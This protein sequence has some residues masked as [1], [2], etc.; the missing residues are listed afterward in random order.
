MNLSD[1]RF[2]QLKKDIDMNSALS[3]AGAGRNPGD[4]T[5]AVEGYTGA[6]VDGSSLGVTKSG[7][8][9][10][11]SFYGKKD[12][13][14]NA[15]EAA[16]NVDLSAMSDTARAN[17]L[18]SRAAGDL[19]A[20]TAE[21]AGDEGFSV[22]F[23]DPDEL[24]TVTDKIKLNLAKAGTDVSRLGG[25]SDAAI[26][27]A[28]GSGAEAAVAKSSL[29]QSG[30]LQVS[31]AAESG[32]LQRS[33]AA[34][35]VALQPAAEK[36]VTAEEAS[37]KAAEIGGISKD[38]ALYL[39]K[40]G[41]APTID[42]VYTAT[43]SGK[44]ASGDG[45]FSQ[46]TQDILDALD[47]ALPSLLQDAGLPVTEEGKALVGTLIENQIP[48]TP[49]NLKTYDAL[50]KAELIAPGPALD[51][52]IQDTLSAGKAAGE[53]L[54]IPGLED[55][56]AAVDTA[57]I[58]QNAT[59]EEAEA[60]VTAGKE[61]NAL[62]LAKE[63]AARDRAT[64]EEKARAVRAENH[65][66]LA[67]QIIAKTATEA[68]R[69]AG[70]GSAS[71]TGSNES[72]PG[73]GDG[74]TASGSMT[75][76]QASQAQALQARATLTEAQLVMT[77]S[78]SFTLV[79]RGIAVDT[80]PL[81]DL[82][83]QI[84]A[85]QDAFFTALLGKPEGG[86]L[87]RVGAIGAATQADSADTLAAGGASEAAVEVESISVEMSFS[88]RISTYETTTDYISDFS[89]F[90]TALTGAFG[91]ESLSAA[92]GQ[93]AAARAAAGIM[94][95]TLTTVHEQG[96]SLK[97][98]YE[99]AGAA[100]ETYGTE[101]RTDLGD[102]MKKA[103]GNIPKLLQELGLEDTEANEKAVRILG[104]NSMDITAENV[105]AARAAEEDVE[106]TI[107][108]LKPG[109][110]AKMIK[111]GL[112]PLN[113]T[114]ADLQAS[115]ND[116]AQDGGSAPDE[117]FAAFVWKA[118]Q[119]GEIDEDEKAGMIGIARLIYQVRKT[120]GAVIGRLLRQ[121]SPITLQ[122]M[123]A[124]VRTQ[125][126]GAMDYTVDDDFGGVDAKETG[127][128][129][130][131]QQ[132][133]KAFQTKRMSDAG[134]AMTPGKMAA[135]GDEGKYLSM[136]PDAFAGAL[137]A[138][139]AGAEDARV[140][141]AFAE[142]E[143][144]EIRATAEEA[145]EQVYDLLDRLEMPQ[146]P[147]YLSAVNDMIANRRDL[148]RRLFNRAGEE[149]AVFSETNENAADKTLSDVM[150]DLIRDFGEAVKAPKE[151]A[152]AQ[153][154]LYDLAEHVMDGMIVESGTR[155]V[156]VR[157]MQ[158]LAREIRV[159]G[160]EGEKAE[161]YEL[162]VLVADQYGNMKLTIVR[163]KDD[164]KGL[165]EL[166]LMSERLG[167]LRA[168]FRYSNGAV[169]GSL[170]TDSEEGAAALSPLKNNFTAAMSAATGV[171]VSMEISTAATVETGDPF[172]GPVADV[173]FETADPVTPEEDAADAEDS[174][175]RIQTSRLYG[176]A[177]AFIATMR[178]ADL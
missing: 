82:L 89:A 54:L 40:T 174:P 90:P 169:N 132:I 101:V 25:V 97:A 131:S 18:M 117:K 94:G 34:E 118:E 171:T 115:A 77:S 160:A 6:S 28:A 158:Q 80:A 39:V 55:A 161:T 3:R 11:D 69:E 60:I 138:M 52:A 141:Q 165:V 68:G 149:R 175:R 7:L 73:A 30:T 104:Y 151:M 58:I 41:S 176:L 35:T 57:A 29:A 50:T 70:T 125:K 24:V 79:R 92:G 10:R 13:A 81:A 105:A 98:A 127:S 110:I 5:G 102:S 65:A 20:E 133:E 154:A 178:E 21:K 42:N 157:G 83:A 56:A 146:S 84:R 156:D 2:D 99:K 152:E 86:S 130:I 170:V 78:V 74:Q 1:I 22:R 51:A 91:F 124:A 47:G 128:L 153:N 119:S 75:A 114:M 107:S 49:E 43:F 48:M 32:S 14:E 88:E 122:N 4:R 61:L 123:L 150:D 145:D 168:A 26:E 164:H 103:F 95:Q 159:M 63:A 144:R 112:N 137:E 71:G 120:D 136:S 45:S 19:T 8:S 16:E 135:F 108:A 100:Y 162:P 76:Q 66:R 93:A 155:S 113:M 167:N 177:R 111:E 109:V 36:A 173:D 129:S 33:A 59:P 38:A 17:F 96:L 9:V 67:E 116:L 140:E 134:E 148:Y 72:N 106:N 15:V 44:T 23:L 46:S 87:P 163:G 37:A 142:N 12:L 64:P 62:N 53:T 139:Q 166:S 85:Q 172:S 31:A 143:V 121:G 27:E 126:R 147:A